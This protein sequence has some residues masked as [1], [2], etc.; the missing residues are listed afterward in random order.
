MA[1]P[2]TQQVGGEG[3][4][5][6]DHETWIGDGVWGSKWGQKCLEKSPT[7]KKKLSFTPLLI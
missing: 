3:I 4:L 5:G 1:H 2:R 6:I 7:Q